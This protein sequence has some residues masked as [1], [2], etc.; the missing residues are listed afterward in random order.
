MIKLHAHVSKKVPVRGV[1][2]SSIGFAAGVELEMADTSTAEDLRSRISKSYSLL[3][4]CIDSEIANR[5][6]Q[7]VP[8]VQ[9]H[10]YK[11]RP[12]EPAQSNR[13]PHPA[14][15]AQVKAIFAI[16]KSNRMTKAELADWLRAEYGVGKPEDLDIRQA[17]D[18]IESLKTR[19]SA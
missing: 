8:V 15:E 4:A 18:V 17:S 6:Q 12:A 7:S 10:A 19:K 16:S 2:Y 1:D 13:N 3:E 14:T 9:M 11:E 5:E